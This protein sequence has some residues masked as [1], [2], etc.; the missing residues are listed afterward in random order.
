MGLSKFFNEAAQTLREAAQLVRSGL[1]AVFYQAA[2]P[3]YAG[4]P[5]VDF[6]GVTAERATRGYRSENFA[7]PTDAIKR[8]GQHRGNAM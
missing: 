6:A 1:S 4:G 8:N 5:Q 7:P 2:S 3:A